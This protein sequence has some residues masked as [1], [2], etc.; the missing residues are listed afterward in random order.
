M[1]SDLSGTVAARA[2]IQ[3]FQVSTDYTGFAQKTTFL[4]GF[5][6]QQLVA[7]VPPLL[8]RS[9]TVG[10]LAIPK[11]NSDFPELRSGDRVKLDRSTK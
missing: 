1:S 7:I 11:K 8:R 6:C 4:S 5:G 10:N 2:K 3:Q 9:A